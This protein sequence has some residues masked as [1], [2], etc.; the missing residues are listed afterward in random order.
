MFAAVSEMSKPPEVLSSVDWSARNV[1]T[2][3]TSVPVDRIVTVVFASLALVPRLV[4]SVKV[5]VVV[6]EP[7]PGV[8]TRASSSL[9][10]AV[11]LPDRV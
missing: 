4:V 10:I 11:A 2:E 9:V 5:I 1:A 8:K 6:P 3:T 7:A